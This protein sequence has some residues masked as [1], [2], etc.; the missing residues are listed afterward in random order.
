MAEKKVVV[1]K[2][3]DKKTGDK[4]ATDKKAFEKKLG[5]KKATEG[6]AVDKKVVDK[7]AVATKAVEGKELKHLVRI[8]G[9]DLPGGKNVGVALTAIKGIGNRIA[10]LVAIDAGVNAN[11]T[12]GMLDTE[13][14]VKI[15]T[16]VERIG[17]IAPSWMQ[18]RCKDMETG[19]D[20]H[21][22]ALEL[23][24]SKLEDINNMKKTRSYK[25]TRH[26]RHLK[27]RG[28]RTKST[29]RKGSTV[30]ISRNK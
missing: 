24:I 17:D 6:K 30:G 9:V 21:L 11:S 27:V 2:T 7:K 23:D 20:H 5:D 1:K 19:E 28:Q 25:G 22:L 18:N 29:G 12:L 26:E 15:Q 14:I 13:D 10:K 4:K 8:S 3:A 16:S